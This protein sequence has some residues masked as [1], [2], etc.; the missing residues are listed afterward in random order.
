MKKKKK[1]TPIEQET[2]YVAFLKK[3]VESENYKA[4]VTAEEYEKTKVK[5]DKAKFKLKTL[6]AAA[7]QKSK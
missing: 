7:G 6:L 4:V 1:L 2:Q 5:Y 3:Q